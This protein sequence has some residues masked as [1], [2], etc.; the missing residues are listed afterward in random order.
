MGSGCFDLRLQR[1]GFRCGILVRRWSCVRGALCDS[2]TPRRS[3]NGD[4]DGDAEAPR[5]NGLHANGIGYR[6]A[7]TV[8]DATAKRTRAARERGTVGA[9]VLRLSD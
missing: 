1:G 8:A 7:R 9:G 6:V 2:N 3:T 4:D 5:T